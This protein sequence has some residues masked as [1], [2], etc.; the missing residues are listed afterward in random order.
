M[1]GMFKKYENDYFWCQNCSLTLDLSKSILGA[2]VMTN[3]GSL[4]YDR[5]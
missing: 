2:V 3:N 4:V 5:L 1:N